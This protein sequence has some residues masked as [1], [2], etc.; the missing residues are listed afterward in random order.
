MVGGEV[1]TER[2]LGLTFERIKSFTTF[3]KV[4]PARRS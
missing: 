2:P 1:K 3:T 4:A